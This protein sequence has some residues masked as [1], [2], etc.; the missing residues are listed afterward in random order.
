MILEAAGVYSIAGAIIWF[1]LR[2]INFSQVISS[3]EGAQLELFITATLAS[4]FIWFLGENLL[5]ARMFTHFHEHT[6]Y[7]ELLPATAAAYFLQAI[8]ILVSNAAM[9]LFL[10]RRK[11]VGWLAGGFTISFFGFIDGIV[12]SSA[13]LAA[14]FLVPSS[15]IRDFMPYAGAAFVFFMLVAAWWMWR[16]PS[17][18]FEKWLYSRPSLVSFRKANL[19]IYAELLTIRT[20][21]LVPQGFLFWICM[22]AFGLHVPL[23]QVLALSPLIFGV[24]GLGLTPA[25]LGFLQAVAVKAFSSLAPE[26]PVFAMSLSF[27]VAQLIYRM[28][29]GLGSAHAFAQMVL[30]TG[31]RSEGFM[32]PSQPTT[33]VQI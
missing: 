20:A 1:A 32:E 14:G 29:L 16:E 18:R 11:G 19:E 9:V 3:L 33:D 6:G 5:F 15:P 24:G 25:G 17:T 22:H 10:R 12:F 31:G 21:I 28:P 26:A 2:G 30:R 7:R 8:N 4:F 23:V 27:S 13:I